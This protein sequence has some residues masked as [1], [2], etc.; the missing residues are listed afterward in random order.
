MNEIENAWKSGKPDS[1]DRVMFEGNEL[2]EV[3]GSGYAHLER[4]AKNRWCL[5]VGHNDGSQTAIWF[6]SKDLRDPFWER[7]P[8]PAIQ[9]EGKS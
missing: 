8:S 6:K 9:N 3:F 1:R 2:E 4:T 7:R 5:I